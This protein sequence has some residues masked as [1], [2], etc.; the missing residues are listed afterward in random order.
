MNHTE[1]LTVHTLWEDLRAVLQRRRKLIAI[2][3]LSTV[4]AVYIGL[5]FVSDKYEAQASLLVILG[6][7]NAEVPLTVERG[8]VHSDGVRK[9]EV[10]S[11]IALL[12]SPNLLGAAVD[13]VGLDRF[14][15]HPSTPKSSFGRLKAIGKQSY[16]WAR[17]ELD[18]VLIV[19]ALRPRLSEREKARIA[20]QRSLNIYKEKDASVINLSARMSDPVLA[21]DLLKAL[22][23]KY[24]QTHA[25]VVRQE[26]SLMPV[27]EEQAGLYG[28]RLGEL[29]DKSA[30]LKSELGVSS[31][32][33]QKS[34]LLDMLKTAEVGRL[35][36]ERELA[37]LRA[38]REALLTRLPQVP[39]QLVATVVAT[40]SLSQSKAR[41]LLASLTLK[42]S[43]GIAKYE[44]NA[45]PLRVLEEEI[46]EVRA[47]TN[48]VAAEDEGPKTY[49][50]N[51]VVAHMDLEL[52]DDQIKIGALEAATQ[53]AVSQIVQIK[54]DLQ[55]MDI[56]ERDLQKVDLEI[57]IAEARFVAN[58]S[59]REEAR[60]LQMMD[61]R[62]LANISVLSP[63]SFSEKPVAPKRLLIM[64]LGIVAGLL[65]GVSFGL[66]LEWQS[67][68]IHDARDLEKVFE[69]AFLGAISDGNGANGSKANDRGRS[70][71]AL[72]R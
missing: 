6:R 30:K 72:L 67:D 9:E 47:L 31:V 1:E 11:Y 38:A 35:E 68:V 5:L 2:T 57:N 24:L 21:Q 54:K 45:E 34:H 4:V 14:R 39:P 20:F 70:S 28:E 3:A 60:T 65:M 10:N 23:K 26:S 52:E 32:K 51:P 19:L 42:R 41:E 66:F 7:E 33:E 27:F 58:A 40:P 16:H 17:E 8:M 69:G 25:E 15:D 37:R 18:E 44:A 46:A 62:R 48:G 55:K 59:K 61:A 63:P 64:G 29:R 36:N 43:Q 12:N 56:A 53:A 71:E 22:T 13:E 49:M 50:R